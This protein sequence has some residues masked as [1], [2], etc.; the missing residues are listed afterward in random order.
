VF[1][2]ENGDFVKIDM[3]HGLGPIH[4]R[5][6]QLKVRRLLYCIKIARCAILVSTLVIAGEGLMHC[7]MIECVLANQEECRQQ[8]DAATVQVLGGSAVDLQEEGVWI[9]ARTLQTGARSVRCEMRISHRMFIMTWRDLHSDPDKVMSIHQQ[10]AFAHCYRGQARADSRGEETDC[11]SD[12]K[13]EWNRPSGAGADARER[14]LAEIGL[15]M[16]ACHSECLLRCLSYNDLSRCLSDITCHCYLF[17]SVIVGHRWP[18]F[19]KHP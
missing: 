14:E 15:E 2:T 5:F 3:A 13:T 10:Y 12:T 17:W 16:T 18:L 19:G 6:A 4:E 9:R 1:G 11:A 7:F 8:A